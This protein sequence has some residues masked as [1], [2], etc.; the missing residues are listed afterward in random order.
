MTTLGFLH[1]EIAENGEDF[2][3]VKEL[4]YLLKGDSNNGVTMQNLLKMLL[5]LRGV[6]VQPNFTKDLKTLA[7]YGV[8]EV[9]EKNRELKLTE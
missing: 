5:V 1:T 2:L 4:W 9:D 7:F 3:L 8:A 6:N